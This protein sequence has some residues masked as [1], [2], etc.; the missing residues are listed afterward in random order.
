MIDFFKRLFGAR[1]ARVLPGEARG[2]EVLEFIGANGI[3]VSWALHRREGLDGLWA[4]CPRADWLLEIAH[5]AGLPLARLERAIRS[6]PLE[7]DARSWPGLDELLNAVTPALD[8]LVDQDPRH[9]ELLAAAYSS[10]G[11]P[12][13]LASNYDQPGPELEKAW[14]FPA[15]LHAGYADAVRAEIPYRDLRDALWGQ[16]ATGPYR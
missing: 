15:E 7:L 2:A 9:E 6:L 12:D 10:T 4:A 11:T 1:R 8:R 14:G 13:W 16:P 3:I 5:R